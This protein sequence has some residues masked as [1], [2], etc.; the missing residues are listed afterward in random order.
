MDLPEGVENDELRVAL[1]SAGGAELIAYST[2]KTSPGAF[3]G[4]VYEGDLATG[5]RGHRMR[6]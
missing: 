6:R 3:P 5:G 4:R 2:A 1:V